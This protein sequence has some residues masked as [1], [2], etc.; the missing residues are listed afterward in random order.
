KVVAQNGNPYGDGNGR[1]DQGKA[2]AAGKAREEASPTGLRGRKKHQPYRQ[3]SEAGSGRHHAVHCPLRLLTLTPRGNRTES[4]DLGEHD[5]RESQGKHR[6]ADRHG[7]KGR[8]PARDRDW[9]EPSGPRR[10]ERS[11]GKEY[12]EQK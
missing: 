6:R 7:E 12:A 10:R 9:N 2:G 3:S 11:V 8:K 4:G 5:G 1:R